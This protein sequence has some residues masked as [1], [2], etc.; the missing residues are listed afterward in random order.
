MAARQE[1]SLDREATN[2][3]SCDKFVTKREKSI[4]CD[5]CEQLYHIK[6]QKVSEDKLNFLVQPENADA[7]WFCS[8]CNKSSSKFFKMYASLTK[9]QDEM[10]REVKEVKGNVKDIQSELKELSG[11]VKETNGKLD[12]AIEAK[13][14]T[15]SEGVWQKMET[16]VK[17][18]EEGV[19]EKMEMEKRRNNIVMRGIKEYTSDNWCIEDSKKHDMEM[20]SEILRTGLKL[21]ASRHIEEVHRIG[22]Y[23]VGKIRLLRV[24]VKSYEG[25]GEILKRAK[26]LKENDSFK[27]VYIN[28]DLTKKQQKDGQTLRAKLI[29]IKKDH[30][31]AK[32]KYGKIIKSLSGN[33]YDVL[34]TINEVPKNGAQNV[35][36]QEES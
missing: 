6:C 18:V 27:G 2:C 34:F 12:A 8:T 11:L 32:I 26:T 24:K 17:K 13:L 19:V 21:D 3:G 22:K 28:P 33:R 10:D 1:E 15:P 14:I 5:A 35:V 29:E 36:S 25:K 7:H 9:R 20:G 16:R 31:D 4:N 23:E 30:S